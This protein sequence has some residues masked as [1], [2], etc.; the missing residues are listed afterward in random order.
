M[1]Q[2]AQ[3][4]EKRIVKTLRPNYLLF[5]PKAYGANAEQRWP[6]IL[7]LHGAAERGNDLELV[8]KHGIA[9]V[10]EEREDFPFIAVSPQCPPDSWWSEQFDAVTRC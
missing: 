7:F 6:L 3:T 1:R 10:V 4:L 2:R 5:L 8:K 9:K